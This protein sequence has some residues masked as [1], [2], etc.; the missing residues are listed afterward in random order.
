[1][2]YISTPILLLTGLGWGHPRMPHTPPSYISTPILLLTLLLTV[3]L[4]LLLTLPLTVALA[5]VH[6]ERTLRYASRG[7]HNPITLTLTSTLMPY[8]SGGPLSPSPP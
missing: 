2:R 1:M 5:G 7:P 8:A 3:P 4:N 6:Q